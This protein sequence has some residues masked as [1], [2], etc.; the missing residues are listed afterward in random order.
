VP[1]CASLLKISGYEDYVGEHQREK[2][3]PS[4]TFEMVF[5]LREDELRH[6]IARSWNAA[7]VDWAQIAVD[8][9]YFDQSHLIHDFVEFSGVTPSEYWQRQS[10]LAHAGVHVKRFHLPAV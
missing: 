6:A 4:G 1:H 10:Q 3:L 7:K 8:C 2:I 9:G 5:N